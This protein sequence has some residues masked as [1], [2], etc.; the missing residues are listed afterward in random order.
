MNQRLLCAALA[1]AAAACA[2]TPQQPAPAPA[3]PRVVEPVAAPNTKWT[4]YQGKAGGCMAVEL[5]E[6][7][8]TGPAGQCPPPHL[9]FKY[10]CPEG[11]YLEKPITVATRDGFSCVVEFDKGPPTSIKCPKYEPEPSTGDGSKLTTPS[12]IR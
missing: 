3:A 1:C 8:H 6:C 5:D 12:P 2:K 10:E 11:I 9:P 4:V 7:D